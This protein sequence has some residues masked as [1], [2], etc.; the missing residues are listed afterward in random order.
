[1]EALAYVY[2]I[3]SDTS[4]RSALPINVAAYLARTADPQT[5]YT[6]H[7][8][9]PRVMAGELGCPQSNFY[10]ALNTLEERGYIQWHRVAGL[11][12]SSI[13]VLIPAQS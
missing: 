6:I 3:A 4:I 10:R 11:K 9:D 1:M 12:G 8:A 2:Q 7:D 13:R 5:D